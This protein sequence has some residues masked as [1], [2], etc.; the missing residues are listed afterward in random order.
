MCVRERESDKCC[1]HGD[2]CHFVPNKHKRRVY[3][4]QAALQERRRFALV[5]S[6][7]T[8]IAALAFLL[9]L[10]AA[11]VD[12]IYLFLFYTYDRL[13]QRDKITLTL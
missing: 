13:L 6:L 7:R 3:Q 4:Q 1:S 10:T 9:P 8:E 5:S 2:F 12:F 11:F